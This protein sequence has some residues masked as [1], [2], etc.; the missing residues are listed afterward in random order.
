MPAPVL[1]SP[2]QKAMMTTGFLLKKQTMLTKL[3]SAKKSTADVKQVC[4]RFLESDRVKNMTEE[5]FST[6]GM[7]E[8][9]R[10]MD[11]Q[12][13]TMEQRMERLRRHRGD[14]IESVHDELSQAVAEAES[15][16]K[17]WQD[18]LA[19]MQ[20]NLAEKTKMMRRDKLEG[21]KEF[22]KATSKIVRKFGTDLPN[23]YLNMVARAVARGS[24][25]VQEVETVPASGGQAAT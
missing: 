17:H 7:G 1:D 16:I 8:I 23:A 4:T 5:S 11:K 12:A 3:E 6:A 9:L 14:A 2:A 18:T 10:Q 13:A 19:Q 25:N 20:A 21:N 24:G 22:S 15:M